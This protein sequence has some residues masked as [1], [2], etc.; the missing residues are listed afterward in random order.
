MTNFTGFFIQNL[1]LNRETWKHVQI[2][3]A[4]IEPYFHG[5]GASNLNYSFE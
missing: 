1:L 5:F 2:M 3:F 4:N